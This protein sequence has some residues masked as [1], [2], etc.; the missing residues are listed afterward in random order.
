MCYVVSCT[1][2]N[3]GCS[4]KTSRGGR[5]RGKGRGVKRGGEGLLEGS[6]DRATLEGLRWAVVVHHAA[7]GLTLGREEQGA[8]FGHL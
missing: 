7:L 3:A 8:E 6:A 5:S 1:R 2:G 4:T